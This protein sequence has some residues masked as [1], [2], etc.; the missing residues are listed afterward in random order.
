MNTVCDMQ[1]EMD[2]YGHYNV[3]EYN[4]DFEQFFYKIDDVMEMCLILGDNVYLYEIDY[5]KYKTIHSS[6]VFFSYSVKILSRNDSINGLNLLKCWFRKR[7][8]KSSTTP[9]I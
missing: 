1:N 2:F 3:F 4:H 5:Y 7:I 8:C 6:I 9:N